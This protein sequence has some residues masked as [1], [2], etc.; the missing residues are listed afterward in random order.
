MAI[1]NTWSVKD[2]LRDSNDKVL[3]VV[4]SCTAKEGTKEA[5]AGGTID[6][7]GDVTVAFAE[8][9]NDLAT[10]WAKNA[11]GDRVSEIES[12]LAKEITDVSGVPWTS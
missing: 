9:T 3:T 4:Y 6:I 7:D 1:T 11:L 12:L 2:L 10:T 8:I 5:N